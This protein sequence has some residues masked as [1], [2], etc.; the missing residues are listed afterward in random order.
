MYNNGGKPTLID[1]TFS[2]NEAYEYSGGGI[3]LSNSDAII[4]NCVISRNSAAIEGG[5]ITC[6]TS[7]PVIINCVIT[8]NKTYGDG[9]GIMCWG[10]NPVLINCT[11]ARNQAHGIGGGVSSRYKS[12]PII[13]HCTIADNS[14]AQ[15]G[16]AVGCERSYA[17][18]KGS[19]LYGNTAG[20][21]DQLSAIGFEGK[22]SDIIVTSS[23]VQ[24][25]WPGDGNIDA[26]PCFIDRDNGDYRLS[27]SSPCIDAGG[28]YYHLFGQHFADAQGHCRL[29]GEF[30][31]MGSHEF[32]SSPDSDADLLSDVDEITYGSDPNNPDT[33]A[34][35]LLDGIESLR[36]TNP[37]AANSPT[38]ISVPTHYPA[39]Q[40]A[41]FLAFPLET[42]T[43]APGTYYENI[44][45]QGKNLILQSI[46]P[47]DSEIV[48]TTILDANEIGTVVTFSGAE[49]SSCV[50][51]GFTITRGGFS[52]INGNGCE[53]VIEN[54]K[55]LAN[56]CP[57]MPGNRGG[58][59]MFNCDGIIQNNIISDNW[60]SEAGG[61]IERCDGTVRNNII[62]SNSCGYGGG[63][64]SRCNGLITQNIIR[65]NHGGYGAA[66]YCDG[67]RGAM[68]TD[69][70]I[71][72]NYGDAIYGGSDGLTVTNCTIT[73]NGA[74]IRWTGGKL[75]VTNCILWRNADSRGKEL[76]ISGRRSNVTVSYSNV[77]G[78]AGAV[79]IYDDATLNWA[80]GNVALEPRFVRAGYFTSDGLWIAG[81]YHLLPDSPCVDAGSDAGVY[82]DIE[83][84]VRPF[85][86]PEVDNNGEIPDF[87]MGAYEAIIR[88]EANVRIVPTV[89]NR[90]GSLPRI[91][92]IVRLPQGATKDEIAIDKPLI[93]YPG[94]IKAMNQYAIQSA[95][96][97]SQHTTI[98]ASFDKAELMNA[99]PQNGRVE[100]RV[101]GLFETGKYFYGTDTVTII[102]MPGHT[103]EFSRVET[104][105]G[106]WLQTGP[107]L[108]A[109]LDNSGHVNFKDFAFMALH[110]LEDNDLSVH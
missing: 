75:T 81:D 46:N 94:G 100:L 53:A 96:P 41:L 64:I 3:C 9:A 12:R 29:A 43:V 15:Y 49:N 80:K 60:A 28:P 105:S 62:S 97:G 68:I 20:N 38:G 101:F 109:D 78:G 99:V 7:N 79:T 42:V 71:A 40:Q 16:G 17:V 54:C 55:I 39:V 89:I 70:L 108:D 10:S 50:L 57:S 5:G 77:Q 93:L 11:I 82:N 2:D 32:G 21:P 8:D 26:D 102:P 86:F 73:A 6:W 85:D 69:C 24:L 23:D 107:D 44:H 34:D 30:P 37:A 88:T 61:G 51:S 87:D 95:R 4:S 33:D 19:I 98:F 76:F 14:A 35:G 104:L 84:N 59:G 91:L 63:A 31:D 66:I 56:F 52:G 65:G 83:G 72:D 92:A 58:G 1:C 47:L 74:G 25:G 110:W 13:T 48:E 27:S 36:G 22:P 45:F 106:Q 67:G 18:I 90:R 103:F